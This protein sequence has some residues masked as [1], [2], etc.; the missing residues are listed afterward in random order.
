MYGMYLHHVM[1][2]IN[3]SDITAIL[4]YFFLDC[5]FETLG[6]VVAELQVWG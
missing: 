1:I 6:V 4:R 5:N 2:I 3:H